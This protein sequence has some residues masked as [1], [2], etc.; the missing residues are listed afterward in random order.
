[1]QQLPLFQTPKNTNVNGES[2]EG[3]FASTCGRTLGGGATRRGTV[4][5][6]QARLQ[7]LEKVGETKS[8]CIGEP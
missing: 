7:A 8:S 5:A 1:V 6:R 3:V 4:D 2:G